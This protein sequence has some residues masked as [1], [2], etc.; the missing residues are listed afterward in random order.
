MLLRP[1]Q[2][3]LVSK[4]VEALLTHGNTLAVAP[5]GAGKSIMISAIL[6]E[7]FKGEAQK[8]C[9]LAHRDEL[10]GQNEAKFRR[11]NP[12]L[13]TSVFNAT[14][15]NWDGDVTFAMV[16]TLAREA[17]LANMPSLDALVIDEAHHARAESYMRIIEQARQ[18]NPHLKLLGM[19]ATPMRGDKKG[20]R[21]IFSNVADQITV[22]E[23][24]ASGHLVPPKTFVMNVGVQD[25]LSQVRKVAQDFDMGA[26]ANIMNK[27]PI[28]DAVVKHWKEKAEHLDATYRQTVVFCST[29]EHAQ[30]VTE[31]FC[32]AGIK[33][34]LIWGDRTDTE[35]A[36]TLADYSHGKIQVIV[37][38]SVLTEGW[39]HPPTSCVVLLRPSSH[40][41]T[42]VQMIGRGL[43]IVDPQ[44]HPG[45][46]KE[47]CIVLDFGT[48]TLIHGSLEQEIQ[49]DP[50]IP[51]HEA[52]QKDCPECEAKVPISVKECPLC[53]YMWEFERFS[54]EPAPMTDFVM[55]EIDILK[56]SSFLWCNISQDTSVATGFE[57][58]GCVLFQE[59]Q[60]HAVGGRKGV[61]P[62][63]LS[64]KLLAAGARIVCFAAADDWLNLS[65]TENTAHKTRSWLHESPTAK[66][67][68]YLPQKYRNDISLTRYKASALITLQ[69]NRQGIQ[70]VLG[71][72]AHG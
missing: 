33:A 62:K 37:N 34:A 18:G 58:W 25:E 21:P 19:T 5:T 53:G 69:F 2:K 60:W 29:V 68:Q 46:I 39:D 8:A 44:E 12:N 7:L 3:E 42:L 31:S 63:G 70:Q 4:T 40:K 38:V 65:E 43:R 17:N 14:E 55:T 16:Q 71:G 24:I 45:I 72:R 28:N 50:K 61:T 13:S 1:R 64:P 66:Q 54:S 10:T 59:G 23:L 30:D 11:V 47:D 15:K 36:S 32:E 56:R 26:V 27:R 9:V 51:P 6:G 49:L 57:A 35:R 41:S 48:S 67:L 22:K 52:P 20:L